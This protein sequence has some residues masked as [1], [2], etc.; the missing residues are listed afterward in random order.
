MSVFPSLKCFTHLLTLLAP[1]QTSPYVTHRWL[2]QTSPLSHE[3][4][5]QHTDETTCRWQTFSRSAWRESK[6]CACAGFAF[7]LE[8]EETANGPLTFLTIFPTNSLQS[9]CAHY[10]RYYI[11]KYDATRNQIKFAWQNSVQTA[12]AEFNRN[13]LYSF[14]NNEH[15]TTNATTLLCILFTWFVIITHKNNYHSCIKREKK[16]KQSRKMYSSGIHVP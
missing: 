16:C 1:M 10:F 2:L 11:R 13:L 8:R 15:G 9:Y 3:I 6:R 5:W 14:G 12:N 7:M 4:Q